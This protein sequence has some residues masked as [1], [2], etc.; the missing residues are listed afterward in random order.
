MAGK[1]SRKKQETGASWVL[2]A[3]LIALLLAAITLGALWCS[4][5]PRQSTRQTMRSH[6]RPQNHPA[7]RKI[8][9]SSRK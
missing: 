3:V 9:C 7:R 2:G 4:V 1:F 5:R 6:K 8:P